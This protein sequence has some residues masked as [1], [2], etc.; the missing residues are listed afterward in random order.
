[1]RSAPARQRVYIRS[2]LAY[3]R[4][5][6]LVCAVGG[7]DVFKLIAAF[8]ALTFAMEAHALR[9]GIPKAAFTPCLR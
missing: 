5:R 2:A 4:Q 1:M 8:G 7:G 9:A 6:K 3:S